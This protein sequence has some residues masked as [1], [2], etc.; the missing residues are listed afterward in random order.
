MHTE[1]SRFCWTRFGTE[2]GELVSDIVHRKN[3]ERQVSGGMFL[4]GI[5]NSVG[6]AIRELVR[7]ESAPKVLFSPMRS[8]PKAVDVRPSRVFA[9]TKA[10]TLE[11]EE[12][13]IPKGLLVVS[14]GASERGS[15]K[16]VHY[17][18]VC[19]SERPLEVSSSARHV[20]YE[21]LVN[22]MSKSRLGH[23]Q[24]TAVVQRTSCSHDSCA[25]NGNTYPVGFEA[26]LVY[27]YFVRLANPREMNPA[28]GALDVD[29]CSATAASLPLFN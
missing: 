6:P 9:W 14:R 18:L 13:A 1:P 20:C 2:S 27:P 11:G 3:T 21:E 24:V 12:W 25:S 15:H 10:T 8:K 16:S 17:A 22:L 26:D 5:G 28:T 19:R 29:S 7:I 4:W 23:S